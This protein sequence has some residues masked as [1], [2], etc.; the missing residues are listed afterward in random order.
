VG[1]VKE[2]VFS[3]G[4]SIGQFLHAKSCLDYPVSGSQV[5]LCSAL[6]CIVLPTNF[7]GEYGQYDLFLC[8][9]ILW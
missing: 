2:G 6:I 7:S 8:S 5:L 3:V 1:E 4:F 9:R